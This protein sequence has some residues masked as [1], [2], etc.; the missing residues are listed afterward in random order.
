MS[1]SANYAIK[2][3][4]TAYEHAGSCEA[5]PSAELLGE[6]PGLPEVA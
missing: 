6:A 3:A 2:P 5:R 4:V 1:D